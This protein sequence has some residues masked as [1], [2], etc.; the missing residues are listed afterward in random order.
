MNDPNECVKQEN[1]W[2]SIGCVSWEITFIKTQ[3]ARSFPI[4]FDWPNWATE[5]ETVNRKANKRL[6]SEKQQELN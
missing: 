2:T 5:V 6:F 3:P 1:L 4:D